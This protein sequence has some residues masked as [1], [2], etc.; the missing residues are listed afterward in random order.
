MNFFSFKSKK[1]KEIEAIKEKQEKLQKRIVSERSMYKRSFQAATRDR[2]HNWMSLPADMDKDLKLDLKSMRGLSRDL[3]QN[4]DYIKRY[5]GMVQDHVIGSKGVQLQ[6][7]FRDKKGN[8]K[9]VINEQI[10]NAFKLWSRKPDVTGRHSWVDFQKLVMTAVARDG[11]AIVRIIYNTDHNKFK[12]SLQLVDSAVLDED[13]NRD[14]E[15]G[16]QIRLGVE[17]DQYGAPIA[18]YLKTQVKTGDHIYS[19][20]GKNYLRVPADQIIHIFKSERAVQNRGYPWIH[21]CIV[22][23][24]ALQHYTSS[25]VINARVSANKMGF[26]TR[27]GE[28]SDEDWDGSEGGEADE[29]GNFVTSAEPGSFEVLPRNVDFK[30]WNPEQPNLNHSDFVKSQLRGIASGLQVSYN[31]LANDLQGVNFSSLRSGLLEEREHWKGL[32]SFFIDNFMSIVFQRWINAA[33]LSGQLKIKIEDID[34]Y[35]FPSFMGR[36]WQWVDPKKDTDSAIASIN[37]GLKSRTEIATE[38][39]RSI[40]DVFLELK[41]EEELIKKFGIKTTECEHDNNQEEGKE[42]LVDD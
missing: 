29:F 16:R 37:A 30:P 24:R 19:H 10:E 31:S 7:H 20:D 13:F 34:N 42:D 12:F 5:L 36:R 40:E 28:P 15:D 14:Y 18:Y 3:S 22:G 6:C 17:T 41:R 25:V 39:G 38:Q 21:T 11:E 9:N 8:L 32:Q 2:F 26:Y 35:L 23:L 4:N 33:V 1:R 27:T